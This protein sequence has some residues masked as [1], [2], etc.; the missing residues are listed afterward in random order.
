MIRTEVAIIGAGP[1]GLSLAAHLA[2]A[3]IETRIFGR[4]MAFWETIAG[5]APERYLKSYCFG[6]DIPMPVNGVANGARFS[7]WSAARGLESFEPCAMSAFR[8]YGLDLQRRLVPFLTATDVASVVALDGGFHLETATG[9]SLRA[10]QVVVATGLSLFETVP[11]ELKGLPPTHLQHS[12]AVR[13][14]GVYRGRRVAILGG[15]QS[16]L[17]AAALVR[18]AG[19]LP[20]LIVREPAIRWMSRMPRRRSL[21][22]RLRSPLSGLGS[23]PKAWVLTNLPGL[24]RLLPDGP[25]VDFLQRHLPPEGAWW[26]RPRVEGLVPTHLGAAI[27]G[28]RMQGDAVAIALSSGATLECDAVIAATGFRVDVDRLGFLAPALRQRIAR[29]AGAPRLDARFQ[30]SVPGLFFAGPSSA[31]SFGPLFRFVIG[32]GYTSAT[33]TAALRRPRAARDTLGLGQSRAA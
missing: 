30:S 13:D 8:D 31:V 10:E 23:G 18:E 33:L 5:A 19:G 2:A 12:N 32:A 20:E 6:T 9:E 29:L 27:T 11:A 26:L 16:A 15:G 21:L 17:E 28:A 24:C 25:R 14:Y 3:G 22:R 4:P 7:D 1:Y